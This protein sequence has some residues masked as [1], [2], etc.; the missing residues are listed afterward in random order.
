MNLI[1]DWKN[2][3]SLRVSKLL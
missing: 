1:T 2:F 3:N